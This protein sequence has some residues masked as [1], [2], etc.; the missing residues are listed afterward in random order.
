MATSYRRPGTNSSSGKG[1]AAPY[2]ARFSGVIRPNC[3]P[4]DRKLLDQ[5]RDKMRSLHYSLAT[6]KAYRHWIVEFLR[7]H[8]SGDEWKHPTMLGK[9]EIEAF[10]THLATQRKVSAKTQNQAFS[11]LLFLYRNVLQR[12]LGN[13]NAARASRSKRLP[14]LRMKT[15]L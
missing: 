2:N 11:A 8:R 4:Q 13:L 9:P 3:V 14:S 5:F 1:G 10:L 15:R 6:E 12:K 7:H